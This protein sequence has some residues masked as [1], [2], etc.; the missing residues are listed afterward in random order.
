MKPRTYLLILFAIII[1]ALFITSFYIANNY[2]NQNSEDEQEETPS[3]ESCINLGCPEN[4]IY[5]GSKN[6]DKYYECDCS[7]AKTILP[8]NII[9]FA[10]DGEALA[11]DYVKSGC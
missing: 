8:Q 7:Y 2:F 3:T 6:S 10:T 9:C 1:L 11:R 4:S 5:V